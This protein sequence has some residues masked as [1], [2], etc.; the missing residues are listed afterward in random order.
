MLDFTAIDVETANNERSSICQIGIAQVR[1]GKITDRWES[2]VDPEERFLRRNTEVHG[3]T[4]GDVYDSP[5]FPDVYDKLREYLD[6]EVVISHTSFDRQAIE[7]A[8]SVY[9]CKSLAVTWLDS[10]TIV[11]RTWPDKYRRRGWGLANVAKD[12]GISFGHHDAC[13]DAWAAAQV[14]LSACKH[15]DIDI[16]GWLEEFGHSSP[17]S[18]SEP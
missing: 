13:E 18:R 10:G 7:G 9:G 15:S 3:I 4:R 5:T 14:V 6:G 17:A 8:I 12:L 1:A 2:L 16:N 11:R